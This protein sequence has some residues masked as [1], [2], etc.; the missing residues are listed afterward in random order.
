[1]C[2]AG[3]LSAC[4]SAPPLPAAGSVDADK[5]L[6]DRGME[7]LK[8]KKWL[9]A[10]EYFRRLVDGYPQSKFRWDAKL[11]IGDSYLAEGRIDSLILGANEYREFL[12]FSPL[13]ERADYAQYKLAV[14]QSRQVLGPARDQTATREALREVERFIQAYPNSTLRPEVDALQREVRDRLSESEFRVG[15]FYYRS[16][17]DPGALDRF[18]VLLQEDPGFT[19]RDAVYYYMAESLLR[20]K[21]PAEALPYYERLVAEFKTSDFLERAQ[22]RIKE[23][24]SSVTAASGK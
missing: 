3:A 12:Q 8:Q 5:F 17:W 6:Y 18:R 21:L 13:H 16:R 4:A 2:L 15:L 9:N 19:R 11:G 24:K 14:A 10:R 1:V 23:L 7:S 20:I 22:K